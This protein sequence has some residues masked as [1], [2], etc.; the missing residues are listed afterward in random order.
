MSKLDTQAVAMIEGGDHDGELHRVIGPKLLLLL[1]MGDIIGAGIF[2]IT[3][4]VA[5]QVGGMAWLVRAQ[6]AD[7][8]LR[9]RKDVEVELHIQRLM[10]ADALRIR[11]VEGYTYWDYQQ[12][13]FPKKQGMR[14]DFELASPALAKTATAA[15]VPVADLWMKWHSI[16]KALPETRCSDGWWKW[17]CTRSYRVPAML[18]WQPGPQLAWMV[19]PSLTTWTGTFEYEMSSC[20]ISARIAPSRS[21]GVCSRPSEQERNSG[22]SSPQ[23]SG[24]LSPW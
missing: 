12:L 21:I 15:T 11:G 23:C 20:P 14:I 2:A 9:R 10:P 4:R 17:N 8:T 22:V 13:R 24:P 7:E 3:G 5:G 16:W 18:V 19:L 1:I 6:E